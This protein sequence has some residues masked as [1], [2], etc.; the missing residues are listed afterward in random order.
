M[1]SMLL[2]IPPAP[3]MLMMESLF[4]G[5]QDV[6]EHLAIDRRGYIATQEW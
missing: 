6:L 1:M 2:K 3:V 4:V 5:L